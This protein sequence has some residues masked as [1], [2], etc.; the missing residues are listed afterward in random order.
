VVR[1]P[2]FDPLAGRSEPWDWPSRGPRDL[3]RSGGQR[4]SHQVQAPGADGV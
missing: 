1:R 4:R 3:G 2:R